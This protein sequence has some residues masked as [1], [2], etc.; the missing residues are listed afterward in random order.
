MKLAGDSNVAP[1]EGS[2]RVMIG[3]AFTM[4]VTAGVR[5]VAP[6]LSVATAEM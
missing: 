3:G 5:V 2:F 6:R 1:P 4:R